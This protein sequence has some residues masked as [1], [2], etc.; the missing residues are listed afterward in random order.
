MKEFTTGFDL[1][2]RACLRLAHLL[3]ENRTEYPLE[4]DRYLV[5]SYPCN[6]YNTSAKR[7]TPDMFENVF[8]Q[9]D[10]LLGR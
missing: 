4:R 7:L 6:R 9:T 2:C 1:D 10:G 5:T 3:D 8:K